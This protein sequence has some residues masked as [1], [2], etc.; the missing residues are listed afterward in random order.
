MKHEAIT[1]L[2]IAAF[3]DVY[4]E[5]G[6]GFLEKVYEN[7]L[8]IELRERMLD[9]KQQALI[10]VRYHGI[11]VGE[12]YADILVNDCVIVELKAVEKIAEA[13][14]AQIINY[15]KATDISVGLLLNFGP[16]PEFKR[17]IHDHQNLS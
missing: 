16:K 6:A 1:R 3:Y 12:Y 10:K 11:E 15:L 9:V 2:I 7:A 8:M 14:S 4:N 13:H 5:L 17:K